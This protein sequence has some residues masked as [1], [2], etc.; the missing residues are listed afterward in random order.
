MFFYSLDTVS[1]YRYNAPVTLSRFTLFRQTTCVS[2]YDGI[3]PLLINLLFTSPLRTV[4]HLL[5]A[6]SLQ[7]LRL[8][9][10]WF[11]PPHCYQLSQAKD[12][13]LLRVH[14]PPYI[15]YGLDYRLVPSVHLG[16]NN[17]RLP[18]L[19]HKLPVSNAILNHT[20]DLTEYWASSYYTDLPPLTC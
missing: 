13:K 16:R 6:I 20:S 11:Y 12:S 3:E 19:L 18:L 8:K 15:L 4:W 1:R 9:S 14:L 10:L 17:V 5:S 2:H 7:D